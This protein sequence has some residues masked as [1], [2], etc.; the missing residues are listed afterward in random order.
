MNDVGQDALQAGKS[1]QDAR[2]LMSCVGDIH[3]RGGFH[4]PNISNDASRSVPP[5]MA[6]AEVALGNEGRSV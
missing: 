1:V 4:N 6:R 5:S 2:N 3:H